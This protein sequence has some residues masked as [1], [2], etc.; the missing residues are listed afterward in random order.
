MPINSSRPA[1]TPVSSI[2]SRRHASSTV[3]PTSTNPP[4]SAYLPLNGGF[5]RRISSRRPLASMTTQSTVSAGVFGNATNSNPQ[6]CLDLFQAL[7][8]R[9][10][11]FAAEHA[12]VDDDVGGVDEGG[13]VGGEPQ[14]A[15]G[16]VVRSEEHT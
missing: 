6:R 5:P 13:A 10:E 14:H 4:G 11:L 3:S 9:R 2:S 15:L 12:A 7:V 16:D 1:L 8:V